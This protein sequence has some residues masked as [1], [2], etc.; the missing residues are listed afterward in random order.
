MLLVLGHA[1]SAVQLMS[2]CSMIAISALYSFSQLV[3]LVFQT[4][5]R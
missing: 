5:K 1:D 3:L 4:R 2:W